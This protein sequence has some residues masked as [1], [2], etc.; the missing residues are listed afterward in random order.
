MTNE[1]S[2]R[3]ALKGAA[4]TA[5]AVS[6]L[7]TILAPK[8]AFADKMGDEMMNTLGEV[9]SFSR[10][11][12]KVHTYVSPAQAVNVTSHVLELGDELLVVDATFLPDTAKE[13]AALIKHTG[14]SV[15][16]A[17]LSHEHPDHWSGIGMI[18][19]VNYQ[20]VQGVV[21]DVSAEAG[22]NMP[23]NLSGDLELGETE[24]GGV[25][26]GFRNYQGTESNNMVVTVLPEQKIAIVQD[27]VYNGV[28]FAP[29]YD[30]N[31][32]MATLEELRADEAFDTL[33]V[34]HG[35]PTTRGELD[36]AIRYLR[37]LED[38]MSAEGA[39]PDAVV[40]TMKE[41]FPGFA[42][43][44]LLSLIAEYWPN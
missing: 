8:A 26:V 35:L 7:G 40:A 32:W 5:G 10:G 27:L 1:I 21:D 18:E 14:K 3:G 22:E 41:E 2:R 28:Y 25:K 13:V 12:V 39:T 43:E 29:G 31:K 15:G 44:F 24:I 38:A 6:L 17:I 16:K 42:G 34:G 4:M 33:L 11:G 19:G 37:V 9:H 36:M 23:A 20:T 30:R